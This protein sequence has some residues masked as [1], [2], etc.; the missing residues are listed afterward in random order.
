[1]TDYLVVTTT[2]ESE[3]QARELAGA[4]VRERL[5]ACAQVYPVRSVYWWE[6]E[7]QDAEEWRVDLKTR[8]G[9]ARELREFVAA[10]HAYDTPELIAV[11]VVDGSPAY[12]AWL[13][14]ETR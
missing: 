14:A 2:H 11:P 1:M 7:V 13:A 8:S 6:G 10:R 5:A 4:V 9:L 3:Q 12:L